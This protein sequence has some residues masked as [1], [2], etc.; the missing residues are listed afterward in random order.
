MRRRNNMMTNKEIH[1][2]NWRN[3]GPVTIPAGLKVSKISYGNP[4]RFIYFVEEFDK[5][6]NKRTQP[7][8]YHDAKY[9]GLS[10]D[11]A[12]VSE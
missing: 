7:I 9:Y 5:V 12:D 10:V 3:H 6:F 11:V 2:A 4:T 1:I 8:Q